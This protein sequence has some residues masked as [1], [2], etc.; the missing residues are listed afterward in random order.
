MMMQTDK[1]HT[2][3]EKYF[4][5]SSTL[6][7]E[8]WLR[9]VLPA[10]AGSDPAVD[11]ALAVMGYAAGGAARR[12]TRSWRRGRVAAA[13]SLALLLAAAGAALMIH[14]R[15]S[16]SSLMAYSGGVPVGR[17]EAISLMEAQMDE[18]AEASLGLQLE[19]EADLADFGQAF[20]Q[21]DNH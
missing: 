15:E 10:L 6:E 17:Q 7:E 12:T 19:M 18:L 11:E 21:L 14:E 13:A 1:I 20:D 4:D 2:L 5:G 3:I 16:R 9:T 8:R